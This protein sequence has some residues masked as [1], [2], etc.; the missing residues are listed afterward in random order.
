MEHYFAIKLTQLN[1]ISRQTV[2]ST[3]SQLRHFAWTFKR[4]LLDTALRYAKNQSLTIDN[5]T[6][7]N[8][9]QYR[10]A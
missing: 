1:S 5:W 9:L 6:H 8:P 3:S 2:V 10:L 4:H 7:T